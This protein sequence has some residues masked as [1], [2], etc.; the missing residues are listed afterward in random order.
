[1]K[2]NILL[3]TKMCENVFRA[4]FQIEEN[5]RLITVAN[6]TEFGN[7]GNWKSKQLI[8]LSPDSQRLNNSQQCIVV[9]SRNAGTAERLYRNSQG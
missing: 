1:M 9:A 6:Y 3:T 5:R 7:F 8:L 2:K 4:A